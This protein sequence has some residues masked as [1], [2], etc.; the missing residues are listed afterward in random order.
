MM[1]SR[2]QIRLECLK[3]AGGLGN[4]KVIAPKNII[5]TAEQFFKW[6][7]DSPEPSPEE[8]AFDE[9]VRTLMTEGGLGYPEAIADLHR[10]M[11]HKPHD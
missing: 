10:R 4:A 7:E 5:A 3:M 6:V 9:A 2:T 11:G 8:T 1:K